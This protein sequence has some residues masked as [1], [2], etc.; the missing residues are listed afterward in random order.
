MVETLNQVKV[1][2]GIPLKKSYFLQAQG[3]FP[4]VYAGKITEI[5]TIFLQGSQKFSQGQLLQL[6]T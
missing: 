4:T 6:I 3:L 5:A 2:K 1:K